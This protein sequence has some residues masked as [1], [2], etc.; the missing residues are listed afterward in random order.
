[1]FLFLFS[2]QFL[3]EIFILFLRRNERD[4]IINVYKCSCKV[5]IICSYFNEAWTFSTDSREV[6]A[7]QISQKYVQWE[8]S[9]SVGTDTD[10][11]T[12][13]RTDRTYIQT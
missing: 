5:L 11:R 6:F 2:L 8:P 7:Y 4:M 10:G 13:G 1:M 9:C 12:D 3:S